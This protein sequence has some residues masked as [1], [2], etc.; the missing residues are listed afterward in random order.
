MG[1]LQRLEAGGLEVAVTLVLVGV[2]AEFYQQNNLAEQ[3]H[4]HFEGVFG[5][6]LDEAKLETACEKAERLLRES[7]MLPERADEIRAAA[8]GGKV[9]IR[10]AGEAPF[11]LET[12]KQEKLWAI[13]RLWASQWQLDAV[14]ERQPEL[15]PPE[16]SS[17]L[18][19]VSDDLKADD[20]LAEKASRVLGR[21]VQVWTSAGKIV[22]VK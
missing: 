1:Q 15:A 8:P 4:R 3:I 17:L 21:R 7:Y 5:A 11:A 18:Q 2:E 9:L 16:N 12:G 13:K 10:Y 6:R 20:G 14:L 19:S 22:R